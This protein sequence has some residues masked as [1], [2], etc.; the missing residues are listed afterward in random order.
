MRALSQRPIFTLLA[1]LTL[2][3][4]MRGSTFGQPLLHPDE[5]FYLLVGDRW[6][7]QGL[8]P[9]TDIWDRKPVGLF[10][11]FAGIRTLGGDGFLQYQLVAC[12]CVAGTAWLLLDMATRLSNSAGGWLAAVLYIGFLPLYGGYGGQAPVFYNLFMAGAASALLRSIADENVSPGRQFLSGAAAMLL[13][14]IAIQIKTS[15]VFEGVFFGCVLLWRVRHQPIATIAACTFGWISIALAP[16]IVTVAIYWM[17]GDFG[18]LL[19]ASVTSVLRRQG[20]FG[21]PAL[22]RLISLLGLTLPLLIF[23]LLAMRGRRDARLNFLL[24]WASIALIGLLSFGTFYLHYGLAVLPPLSV[25]AAIGISRIG[26]RTRWIGA[27]MAVLAIASSVHLGMKVRQRG[28]RADLEGVLA[29]VPRESW[30]CP[31]FTGPTGPALYLISG[32]C[33]PSKYV[34]SGH[35]FETHEARAVGTDQRAELSRI[36]A[37]RPS[38]ITLQEETGTEEDPAIRAF[39]M[40]TVRKRYKLLLRRKIGKSW[41]QVYAPHTRE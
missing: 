18:A 40:Q 20:G 10:L 14:G 12:A 22:H 21:P 1:L 16:T 32:A 38:L 23:T 3:L 2:S 25:T 29:F 36:I 28:S 26:L 19:F 24:G 34:L 37:A 41:V 27:L 8:W 39:F 13:V 15:T 30:R 7:H 17:H 4:L 5:T 6:Q 11:I 33:L 9:Y 31:Y 35:L